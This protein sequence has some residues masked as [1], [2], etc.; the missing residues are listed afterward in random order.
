MEE[1]KEE[2]RYNRKAR[3]TTERAK[4]AAVGNNVFDPE[5]FKRWLSGDLGNVNKIT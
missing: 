3:L 4:A 1:I 5:A 2:D